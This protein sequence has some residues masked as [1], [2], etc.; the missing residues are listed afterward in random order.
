[1]H[2]KFGAK[3]GEYPGRWFD[4]AFKKD[5]DPDRRA[6][7]PAIDASLPDASVGSGGADRDSP[8]GW[9]FDGNLVT[10]PAWPAHPEWMA[11]FLQA[12]GSTVH[13]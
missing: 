11:K 4:P 6:D 3:A 8:D 10:A 12:L 1:M 9:E 13:P 2:A 5:D 7:R